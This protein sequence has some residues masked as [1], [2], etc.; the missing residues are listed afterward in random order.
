MWVAVSRVRALVL[1][2]KALIHAETGLSPPGLLMSPACRVR[3]I[4]SVFSKI[5]RNVS[6]IRNLR[7]LHNQLTIIII[8]AL[9]AS[10]WT[11]ISCAV[12]WVVPPLVLIL[13]QHFLL[14]LSVSIAV[15]ALLICGRGHRL[16]VFSFGCDRARWGRVGVVWVEGAVAHYWFCGVFGCSARCIVTIQ[17]IWNIMQAKTNAW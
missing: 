1:C 16:V 3:E 17:F 14:L 15:R 13:R 2:S 6:T 4:Q 11:G 12:H 8:I 5:G 7:V 9:V 10:H